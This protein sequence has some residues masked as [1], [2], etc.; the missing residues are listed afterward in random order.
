M[1]RKRLTYLD[2]AKGVGIFLVVLGHIEYI[3]EDTLKWI[4]SFHMPL[5]FIVGG[6]LS[7]AKRDEKK[8]LFTAL[9]GKARGT[10]LPYAAFTIMLLTMNTLGYVLELGDLT[11][12]QLARQYVDAATGYGIHILWFLPAY[13]IAGVVFLLLDRSL[14]PVLR[15]MAVLV[16][17]LLSFG[18]TVV[19]HLDQYA[20]MNVSLAGF[21][22]MDLLITVLRGILAMPFLLMG[23]YLGMLEEKL[24]S[25]SFLAGNAPAEK[26]KARERGSEGGRLLCLALGLLLIPGS[27]LA[28]HSP[29]FDLHYLYVEPLHYLNAFLSC[30]GLIFLLRALPE[31][32]ILAWLGRNSL[33]IMC[34]HAA[35]FVVYYVSLGMFFIDNRIPLPQPVFN[36]GVAVFVCVAVIPIVWIFNRY[37]GYLLGRKS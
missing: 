2:M 24:F 30:T 29:V 34:T 37:F 9:A 11:A 12:S 15:N 25:G 1:P 18:I 3:Q 31:S 21:A 16:L 6:I 28:L 33:V 26:R 10:L 27:L 22:G 5:F 36:L 32:R 14:R 23:W 4:S 17:A 8:P 7:Y 19:F 20:S 35:F 13:F